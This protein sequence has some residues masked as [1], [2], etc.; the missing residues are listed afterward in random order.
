MS[1]KESQKNFSSEILQMAQEDRAMRD[2][3]NETG[4][5][6]GEIDNLNTERMKA[7]VSEIGWPTISKVGDEASYEAWLLVQH[8]PDIHFQKRCLELM[9]QEPENELNKQN[10]A[11]LEDRINVSEGRP[12]KYGTQSDA[13]GKLFPIEDVKRVNEFRRL[14]GMDELEK[15]K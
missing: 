13:S 9:K 6:S 8:S 3:F 10:I 2:K 15:N 14:L 5:F 1:E 12:Q 11:Y 4:E 7:I